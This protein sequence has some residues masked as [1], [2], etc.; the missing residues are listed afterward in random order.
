M[1]CV[2]RELFGVIGWREYGCGF[3][4]YGEGDVCL[5]VLCVSSVEWSG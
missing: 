5:W 2:E 4:C 1:L 3:D